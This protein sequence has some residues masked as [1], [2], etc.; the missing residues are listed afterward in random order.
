MSSISTSKSSH[1]F[2]WKQNAIQSIGLYI[3]KNYSS[4]NAS[5]EQISN[6]MGKIDFE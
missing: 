3:S 1:V 6:K 5:F 2:D 4:L